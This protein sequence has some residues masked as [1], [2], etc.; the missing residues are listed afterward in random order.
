MPRQ[1]CLARA[2]RSR[3]SAQAHSAQTLY[4]SEPS[5]ESRILSL[6]RCFAQGLCASSVQNDT[7]LLVDILLSRAARPWREQDRPIL[8]AWG[9]GSRTSSS[10]SIALLD[11]RL[12]TRYVTEER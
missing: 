7:L 10:R 6:R 2:L 8:L 5:E 3:N 9:P 4:H 12:R 1:V 11:A